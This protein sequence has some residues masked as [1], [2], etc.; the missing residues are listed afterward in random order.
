[1]A[2]EVKDQNGFP[3][4]EGDMVETKIRGGKLLNLVRQIQ[5]Q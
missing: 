5:D 2:D 4:H 3:I 1:M